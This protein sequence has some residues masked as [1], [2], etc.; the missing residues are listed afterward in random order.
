MRISWLEAGSDFVIQHDKRADISNYATLP[1]H[2]RHVWQNDHMDH[3]LSSLSLLS[4]T[5]PD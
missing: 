1:I 4:K 2:V 3:L 5:Q